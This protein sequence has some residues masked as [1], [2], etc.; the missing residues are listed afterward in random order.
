[1]QKYLITGVSIALLGL[2]ACNNATT[3]STPNTEAEAVAAYETAKANLERFRTCPDENVLKDISSYS[4]EMADA[5]LEQ[6]AFFE[7]NAKRQGVITTASGLQYSVNKS[8]TLKTTPAKPTQTVR[9]HYHGQYLNGEMFDSSYER[10]QDIEF[11]LN[12]VIAGWTEGVGMMRP[13][14]A[15][16]FY[17]PSGLAYGDGGRG[18][19]PPKTPLVFHVQ[20]LGISD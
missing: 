4:N 20:L 16:T 17:I 8:S 15:W 7:A 14:D 2:G 6:S 1:M 19:I 5:S 12:R 10:G 18:S 9:V 3:I 11:P 13:C